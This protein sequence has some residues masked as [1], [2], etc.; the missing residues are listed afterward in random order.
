MLLSSTLQ[1][2]KLLNSKG[3]IPF[4]LS[5]VVLIS[6][7][8][9]AK[10]GQ[11]LM[12]S[13]RLLEYSYRWQGHSPRGESECSQGAGQD[14][15]AELYQKTNISEFD[16]FTNSQ[17]KRGLSDKF[18]NVGEVMTNTITFADDRSSADRLTATQR[19]LVVTPY[20]EGFK[21]GTFGRE[22]KKNWKGER[23]SKCW[24]TLLYKFVIYGP[25]TLRLRHQKPRH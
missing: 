16:S 9:A 17:I 6:M 2:I 8:P 14:L 10:A 23:T 25:D 7:T 19:G 15:R 24:G 11:V 4:F 1:K 18:E 21:P 5:L 13:D 12:E 3:S 20:T 22:T